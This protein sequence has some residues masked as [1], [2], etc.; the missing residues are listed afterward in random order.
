MSSTVKAFLQLHTAVFLAGFTGILG[1]LITINEAWLVWY[2]M[3]IAFLL[4]L[5][6]AFIRKQSLRIERK[7]LIRC[8]LIGLLIGFHWLLF[9]G[10]VKYGNVSVAVVCFAA[11]GSFTALLEPVLF[12]RTFNW[13]ELLLGLLVLL[14]IYL[15]FQLDQQYQTAVILGVASAFFS[16]L[17]PIFNKRMIEYVK[18][19]V[20]TFYELAGGWFLL[21]LVLPFYFRFSPA[22]YHIPTESD[23][24]WLLILAFFCTVVAFQLSVNALRVIS[25]FTANL[26]YNLEPLYGM[27]LAFFMFKEQNQLNAGFYAGVSLILLSVIIQTFI[28]YRKHKK[29]L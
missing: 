2:R 20:L 17:F 11:T 12:K 25:P 21:S 8:L 22:T 16:A 6:F 18:A 3:L 4:L 28:V 13:V 14:G 7:F 19:P 23:W 10:S 1:R 9:Y 26:S 5:L 24:F 15:I 27:A 29:R